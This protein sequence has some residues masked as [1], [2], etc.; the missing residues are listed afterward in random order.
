MPWLSPN[1]I[2]RLRALQATSTGPLVFPG[3]GG[4]F[5]WG[6]KT[7]Y[8]KAVARLG[9]GGAR[10][11]KDDRV[12]IHTLRHTF[13]SRLSE[14][15]GDL[16][17]VQQL[18]GWSSLTLVQRYTRVRAGRAAAALQ[19]MH[20]Q[21]EATPQAPPPARPTVIAARPRKA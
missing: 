1:L 3:P 19:Q 16:L 13:A 6:F 17:L 10:V 8:Y 9:L 14:A 12:C 11:P 2:A 15:T 4:G 18:G 21:R 7:V 20:A 5:R